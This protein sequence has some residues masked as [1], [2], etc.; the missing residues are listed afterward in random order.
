MKTKTNPTAVQTLRA[1]IAYCEGGSDPAAPVIL[2]PFDQATEAGIPFSVVFSHEG[3][4]WAV[5]VTGDASPEAVTLLE[6][7][8]V[9]DPA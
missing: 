7:A 6:A 4:Q 1:F 5:F 3:L 2:L 8:G 9:I